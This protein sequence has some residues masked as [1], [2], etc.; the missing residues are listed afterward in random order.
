MNRDSREHEAVVKVQREKV[1]S[2]QK[3]DKKFEGES[4]AEVLH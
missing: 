2:E 3:E 1:Q 4:G